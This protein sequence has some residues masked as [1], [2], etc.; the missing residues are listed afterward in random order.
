MLYQCLVEAEVDHQGELGAG[1]RDGEDPR[2]LPGIASLRYGELV[3]S[4][5]G[6]PVDLDDYP[7]FAPRH[8]RYFAG[9]GAEGSDDG[10]RLETSLSQPSGFADD[11]A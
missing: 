9:T 1:S 2:T 10:P 4:G 5:R 8:G 7:P 11:G 6:A 3:L